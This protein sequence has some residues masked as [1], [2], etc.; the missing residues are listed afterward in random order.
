MI[1]KIKSLFQSTGGGVRCIGA[2]HKAG[3]V[4]LNGVFREVSEQLQIPFLEVE[5]DTDWAGPTEA[6]VFNHSSRFPP[7]LFDMPVHG[8]RIV[9]D[10]R[11]IVISGAHYHGKGLED[12]LLAEQ[13]VFGGKSYCE[14]INSLPTVQEKYSFEMRNTAG[15]V[16]RQMVHADHNKAL[17]SFI[18]NNFLMIRYET[19]INDVELLE[20]HR[21]CKQLKL[22][23]ETV[24]PIFV[25][26]SLFGGQK[27]DG[28]HIRSGKTEQWKTEF[29]RKTADE[30]AREHQYALEA[31]GYED[32]SEW[33]KQL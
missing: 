24:S 15:Y 2:Y 29:T 28:K 17:N 21:I 19:L 25:N 1:S 6:L 16:I 30:F 18:E 8:L 14:T 11:D 10:P 27:T 33:V 13:D 3:T 12:W 20:V 5:T 23:F 9:R 7:A 22:P 31:L 26:R 32:N 4:W